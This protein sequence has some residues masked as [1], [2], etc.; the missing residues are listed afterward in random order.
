MMMSLMISCHLPSHNIYDNYGA[1]ALTLILDSGF[2][3][4]ADP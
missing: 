2:S 1:G 4:P 3:A